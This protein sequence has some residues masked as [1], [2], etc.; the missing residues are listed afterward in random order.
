MIIFKSFQLT[1]I[2][3]VHN[4]LFVV[5]TWGLSMLKLLI[6]KEC[7]K[8]FIIKPLDTYEISC[9]PFKMFVP[10]KPLSTQCNSIMRMIML[11]IY[12]HVLR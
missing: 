5:D 3:G 10:S 8:F 12:E 1:N 11:I 7:A 9:K 6:L 4:M 2:Y